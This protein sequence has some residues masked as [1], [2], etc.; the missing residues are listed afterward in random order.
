MMNKEERDILHEHLGYEIDMVAGAL[1]AMSSSESDWFRQ[2][3]TI[4]GFW[5]HARTL[6]EFFEDRK[7]P[8]RTAAAGHFTDEKI[9]YQIPSREKY[10]MLMND[11]IAHLNY[12]RPCGVNRRSNLTPYRRPIL[13]PLS[14]GFWR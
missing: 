1:M 14:G 6:L 9:D 2:M 5:L 3:S 8:G 10:E 7:A 4:E 12:N 13:T 11:Q